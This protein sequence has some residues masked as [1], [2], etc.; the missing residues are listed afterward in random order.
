M[1][2][3]LR[4]MFLR[5]FGG[6]ERLLSV[7]ELSC[8]LCRGEIHRGEAYY[9]LDDRRICEA[10]LERYARRYFAHRRRRVSAPKKEEE[11]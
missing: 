7:G 1:S 2:I 8:A 11:L 9:E 4:K 3:P 6:R 10:C 5:I